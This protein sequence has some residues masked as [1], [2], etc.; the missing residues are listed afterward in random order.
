M[1][2]DIIAGALTCFLMRGQRISGVECEDWELIHYCGDEDVRIR[3]KII[4]RLKT[5][6]QLHLV[7]IRFE[8]FEMECEESKP[9]RQGFCARKRVV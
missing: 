1:S 8:D 4:M 5:E 7:R 2:V 9:Y 3:Y 6:T